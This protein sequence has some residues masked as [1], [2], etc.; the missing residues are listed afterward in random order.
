MDHHSTTTA[1][2]Q[3]HLVDAESLGWL[4]GKIQTVTQYT[5]VPSMNQANVDYAEG[6]RSRSG[7]FVVDE[8]RSNEVSGL[9][10]RRCPVKILPGGGETPSDALILIRESQSNTPESGKTTFSFVIIEEST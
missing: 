8:E 5:E 9:M 2:C 3:V 6:P 4:D 1:L 10:G 7:Y